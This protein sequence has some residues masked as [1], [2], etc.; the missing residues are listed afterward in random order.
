MRRIL[1]PALLFGLLTLPAATAHADTFGFECVTNNNA[2][3]CAILEAQMEVEVTSLDAN[4]VQF[5]FSNSGPLA[6]SIADIYFGDDTP[7]FN[8]GTLAVTGDSGSGVAFS[9]GCS[10]G[11]LP[12]G[13]FDAAACSDSDE[14]PAPNGVGPSEFVTLTADLLA[15]KTFADLIGAINEDFQFGIHVQ[16]FANG[17]SEGG[18]ADVPTDVTDLPVDITDVPGAEPTTLLLLGSGLAAVGAR[19]RRRRG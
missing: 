10:P 6:S 13:S 7:L 18:E 2:G 15:G 19:L 5:E 9:T 12:G 4:T 1:I 8:W 16:A 3:N 17:G 14:P 11:D